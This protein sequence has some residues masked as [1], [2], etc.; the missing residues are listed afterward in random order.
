[1][2]KQEDAL[3]TGLAVAA[4]VGGI[5]A[6]HLPTVA[7]ARA[8][9]P[10]N[11]HM[12]SGRSSATLTASIVVVGASLLAKDPTVFVIG[13]V[14]VIALDTAHRLANSTDNRNGKL[15]A[16]DTGPGA[17]LATPVAA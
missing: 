15:P 16:S 11:I 8:S 12:N 7:S 17:A 6:V 3:L 2:L 1:M 13:G 5:Y 4:V 14:L 10:G 9:Q